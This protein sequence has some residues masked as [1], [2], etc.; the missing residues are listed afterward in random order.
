M[1]KHLAAG[2]TLTD[3]NVEKAKQHYQAEYERGKEM[4]KEASANKGSKDVFEKLDK[5]G[6]LK[7]KGVITE[8]EFEAK[9]K[10]LLSQV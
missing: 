8:A 10:E 9:K 5:L 2:G 6:E 7:A 1:E 4:A 3:L